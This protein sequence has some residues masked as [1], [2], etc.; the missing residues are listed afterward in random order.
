MSNC[1]HKCESCK[2]R[3]ASFKCKGCELYICVECSYL[4]KKERFCTECV[5]SGWQQYQEEPI[6]W[7]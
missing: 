6:D 4:D 2:I 5:E 1:K 7:R 3:H